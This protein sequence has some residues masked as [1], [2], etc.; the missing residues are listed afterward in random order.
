MDSLIPFIVFLVIFGLSVQL[1]ENKKRRAKVKKDIETLFNKIESFL[2]LK[3][4]IFTQE[5]TDQPG[6]IKNIH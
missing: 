1:T 5:K 3:N 6:K 2:I 4:D